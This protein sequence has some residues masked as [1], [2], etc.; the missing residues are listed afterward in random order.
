MLDALSQCPQLPFLFGF[1]VSIFELSAFVIVL[2]FQD[3]VEL[4]VGTILV[5][6]DCQEFWSLNMDNWWSLNRDI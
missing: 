5:F 1:V 3:H 6:W 4:F 2:S